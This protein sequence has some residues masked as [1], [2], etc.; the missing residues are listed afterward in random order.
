M[1]EQPTDEAVTTPDSQL[2]TDEGP[3]PSERDST[4][5]PP[6]GSGSP[7]EPS[8][9]RGRAARIAQVVAVWVM[10]L[11]LGVVATT[12]VRTTWVDSDARPEALSDSER[13]WCGNHEAD[14]MLAADS[15]GITIPDNFRSHLTDWP[16]QEAIYTM[17]SWGS[18]S[19]LEL[20][21]SEMRM[22]AVLEVQTD[23][24]WWVREVTGMDPALAWDDPTYLRMAWDTAPF[25]R[26]CRAAFDGR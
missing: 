21:N 3:P 11:A 7:G 26:L 4:M 5:P 15:L 20:G 6:P 1:P 2:P 23:F 13:V 10:A 14:V 19:S 18:L 16:E 25:D 9:G 22:S 12:L 24:W 17:R 8:S